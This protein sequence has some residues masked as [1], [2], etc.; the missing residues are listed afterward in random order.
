MGCE[1]SNASLWNDL[2]IMSVAFEVEVE[3]KPNSRIVIRFIS[4]D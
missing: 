1:C 2:W 3:K 4:H